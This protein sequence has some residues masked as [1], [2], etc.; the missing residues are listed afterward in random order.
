MKRAK[1]Y[2]GRV[3]ERD[4]GDCLYREEAIKTAL[5]I[6][7]AVLA[8]VFLAACRFWF[9]CRVIAHR[10]FMAGFVGLFLAAQRRSEEFTCTESA[11]AYIGEKSEANKEPV[12]RPTGKFGI[13]I[14]EDDA[15]LSDLSDTGS[16]KFAGGDLKIHH[17]GQPCR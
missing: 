14:R 12:P 4:D 15:L 2:S 10:S 1:P 6:L 7:A 16:R 13:S 8:L 9:Y 3:K 17:S 11:D 5:R